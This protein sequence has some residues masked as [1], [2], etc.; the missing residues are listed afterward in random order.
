MDERET[1][2]FDQDTIRGRPVWIRRRER[3]GQPL[4]RPT[5]AV[6][7][8]DPD[9]PEEPAEESGSSEDWVE[10]PGELLLEFVIAAV[11]CG[12][13]G[14][15]LVAFRVHPILT[16]L[17]LAGL[18]VG[19]TYFLYR[20][21][22]REQPSASGRRL[23]LEAARLVLVLGGVVAGGIFVFWLNYCAVEC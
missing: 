14:V 19:A 21:L 2:E 1:E 12:G 4:V 15:L 23:I 11:V 10:G 17:T 5:L 20:Q 7:M 13:V 8:T 22:R 9:Q 18:L 6:D 3:S 16:G